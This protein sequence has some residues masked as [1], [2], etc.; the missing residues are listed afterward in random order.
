M[1]LSGNTVLIT[2]GSSG[3]GLALAKSFH[4]RQNKVIIT[5]RDASKLA[6][7]KAACPD[8]EIFSCDL[9]EPVALQRLVAFVRTSHPSLNI[10]VN[11]A[12]VQYAYSFKANPD[13]DPQIDYEIAANLAA[14]MKLTAQLLPILLG[15]GSSAVVNVGSGLHMAPKQSAP[16]YCATKAA[17]H[18]FSK[19]LR[20][21]LAGTDVKVFEI[22]PALVDTPMTAGRG[23]A[24]MTAAALADAFMRDF[25]NDRFESYMGRA[26]LLRLVHRIAPGLADRLMRDS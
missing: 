8:I 3:I 5:G 17:M 1:K 26:K 18:S 22:I 11:N 16:V 12:A 23:K 19:S 24:K 15:N 21:Q 6:E 14:P 7:V 9:T 25:G 2:G 10:L 4:G 20:Y 13:I